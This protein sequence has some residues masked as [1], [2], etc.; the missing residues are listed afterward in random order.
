MAVAS[1]D[2]V[3]P[4]SR[5]RFFGI[6][7]LL[8]LAGVL[9]LLQVPLPLP[10]FLPLSPSLFRLLTLVQP[11]LLLTVMAAIGTALAP[12]VGFKVPLIEALY[13][14]E[15]IFTVVRSQLIPATTVTL[16]VF[17]TLLGL[18]GIADPHLPPAYL[19]VNQNAETLMPPLTRFLYGGITEEI[20]MRWGLMT[21]LV[22]IP[23]KV[24]QKSSGKP[25]NSLVWGAIGVTA[26]LFGAGHLP[27]LLELVPQAS[28]FLVTYIIG[29][30]ALVGLAMGWLYWKRGLEAAIMAHILFHL[31]GLVA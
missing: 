21:L 5:V 31:L 4:L 1:S 6:L 12:R 22:W 3:R 10:D 27:L 7:W 16:V 23:W 14:R 29:L 2:M 30:N 8:G 19:A 28:A 15:R 13:N 25:H 11:L 9:S 26:I 18:Q 20:L 24:L 17:M